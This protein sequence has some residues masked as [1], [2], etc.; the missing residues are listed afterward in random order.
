MANS[1]MTSV[2]QKLVK[3]SG[4]FTADALNQKFETNIPRNETA[5]PRSQ[6]QYSKTGGSIVVINKSLTDT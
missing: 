5:R 3:S 2:C 6:T 4:T 1:M